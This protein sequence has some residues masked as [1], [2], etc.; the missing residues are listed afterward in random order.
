MSRSER[1][2]NRIVRLWLEE[3]VTALPDHILDDVLGQLPATPQRRPSWL[4]WRVPSMNNT[5]R[6]LAAAAAVVVVAL[7]GY[8]L[9][10][11][12]SVGGPAPTEQL[13][14]TDG[15]SPAATPAAAVHT[16]FTAAGSD[17]VISLDLPDGWTTCC[18]GDVQFA[19]IRSTT[20]KPNGM[21][22]YFYAVGNTYADPCAHVLLSPAVGPTVEDLVVA[23]GQLPNETATAPADDTIGG[24]PARYLEITADDPLPCAPNQFFIWDGPQG[25][26][27]WAQGGGQIVRTWVLEVNGTRITVSALRY[28]TSTA[29]AIAEQQAVLDSIRFE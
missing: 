19:A 22:V 6:L 23:L 29:A 20:S 28:S 18:E 11:A 10:I 15:P 2:A 3:G 24:L 7:L 21:S 8:Q 26:Q 5:V 25:E 13:S 1:E 27:N 14:P 9:L 17:V 16:N 4:A 12:P